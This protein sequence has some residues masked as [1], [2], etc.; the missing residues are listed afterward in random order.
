MP[1]SNLKQGEKKIK[2]WAVF[3]PL[4]GEITAITFRGQALIEETILNRK[5][6]RIVVPCTII[7]NPKK[8]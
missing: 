3:E 1:K 8:K 2:A 4:E 7:L 5:R 6:K